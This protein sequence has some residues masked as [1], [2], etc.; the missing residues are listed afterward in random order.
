VPGG[1]MSTQYDVPV[2]DGTWVNMDSD[3][4]NTRTFYIA[5]SLNPIIHQE[6]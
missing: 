4:E 5:G 1:N 6:D 2:A 3:S